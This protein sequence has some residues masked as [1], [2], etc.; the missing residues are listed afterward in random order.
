MYK[1]NRTSITMTKSDLE[2]I[3]QAKLLYM[4]HNGFTQMSDLAFVLAMA[5]SIKHAIKLNEAKP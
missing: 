2:R 5:R 3:R 1:E 4:T